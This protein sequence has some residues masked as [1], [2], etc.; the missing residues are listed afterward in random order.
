[1]MVQLKL[2]IEV[3]VLRLATLSNSRQKFDLYGINR[4]GKPVLAAH[5]L[6]EGLKRPIMASPCFIKVYSILGPAV[7]RFSTNL[8][9]QQP[10]KQ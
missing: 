3:N 2:N 10:Q 5:E 4:V 9:L 6:E 7:M 8:P 1:M